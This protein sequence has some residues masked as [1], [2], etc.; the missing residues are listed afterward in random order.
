MGD[1]KREGKKEIVKVTEVGGK[2]LNFS[3]KKISKK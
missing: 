1:K 3:E 2:E